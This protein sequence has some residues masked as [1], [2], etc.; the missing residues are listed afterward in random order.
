[1]MIETERL[2]LRTFNPNDALD[3]FE[4]LNNP[5]APCFFSMKIKSVE[6]AYKIIEERMKDEFYIA[7]E[8]KENHKVIGE[9]FGEPESVDPEE[10]IMDTFSPCWMLNEAY[11]KQ[12][13]MLEALKAYFTW[14]F[15][16]KNIRRI[17]VYTQDYNI[18]CQRLCTKL[19]MRKEGEF[20]EFVSFVNDENNNPR[21]DN[22]WQ[23]AILKPEWK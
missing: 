18:P 6:E 15:S 23:Y 11:Q 19:G 17:Y 5:K 10:G 8:L 7:I 2:I 9:I 4:Y 16:K 14:L 21:Y 1:M 12:S 22:T 13:Y 20:K 3:V